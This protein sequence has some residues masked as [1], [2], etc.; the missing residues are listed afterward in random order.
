MALAA[1]DPLIFEEVQLLADCF[2][3][4]FAT[5]I[6]VAAEALILRGLLRAFRVREVR[7]CFLLAI[8][9]D[10][11]SYVETWIE[12]HGQAV[13]CS[14]YKSRSYGMWTPAAWMKACCDK[15]SFQLVK[16]LRLKR[17]AE[18]VSHCV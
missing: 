9:D 12:Q 3:P 14:N 11:R 10:G 13:R 18:R 7:T 2:A 1:T 5:E 15:L 8:T 4:V 17:E 6:P 16:T